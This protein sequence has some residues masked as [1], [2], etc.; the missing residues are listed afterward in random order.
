MVVVIVYV[1]YVLDLFPFSLGDSNPI[2]LCI[3]YF[4]F[5]VILFGQSIFLKTYTFIRGPVHKFMHGWI[6]LAWSMIGRLAQRP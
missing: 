2:S 5:H 6:P 3:T 4:S 1:A